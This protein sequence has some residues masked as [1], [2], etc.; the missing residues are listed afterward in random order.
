MADSSTPLSGKAPISPSK[1][2]PVEAAPTR[3]RK[4]S[5]SRDKKSTSPKAATNS[6]NSL[7]S[8]KSGKQQRENAYGGGGSID[9]VGSKDSMNVLQATNKRANTVKNETYSK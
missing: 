5:K 7:E 9:D 3:H 2:L 4:R 6:A 8:R 1:F